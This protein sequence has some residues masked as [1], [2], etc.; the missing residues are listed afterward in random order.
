MVPPGVVTET[1]TSP[2]ACAGVSAVAWVVDTMVTPVA[3]TPPNR[4]CIPARNCVPASVTGVPPPVGP[5]VGATVASVGAS[6]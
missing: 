1:S 4:T 3:S 5:V 2:A 6:T